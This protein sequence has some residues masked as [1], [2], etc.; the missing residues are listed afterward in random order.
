MFI[1]TLMTI[2][3]IKITLSEKVFIVKKQ[4]PISFQTFMAII[5]NKVYQGKKNPDSAKGHFFWKY[6]PIISLLFRSLKS[7][8]VFILFKEPFSRL[9]Q[10]MVILFSEEK[11]FWPFLNVKAHTLCIRDFDKLNLIWQ[12]DF[13]LE[14]I[15]DIALLAPLKKYYL[16]L[17]W[18]KVA[19][20]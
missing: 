19:W 9:S 8:F 17:K 16:L 15:F 7:V 3:K 11:S 1:S 14:P 20:K 12:F 4:N 6:L 2:V 10:M 5:A 18:S 13:R